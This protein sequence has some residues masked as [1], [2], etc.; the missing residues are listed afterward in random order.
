MKNTLKKIFALAIVPVLILGCAAPQPVPFKLVDSESRI[1]KGTIFP[2][3]GQIEVTVD[4]QQYK[5]FYIAATGVA[6]S[7]SFGGWRS[8]PRNTVTTYSSNSARAQLVTDS[9][10][11]LSCD[12]LFEDK[13]AIG[14]C[15]SPSGTVYQLVAD[16]N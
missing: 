14:Q 4:G 15:R 10:L 5:G 7:E 9:G 13:R 2:D 16:G 8:F 6:Y 12:F 1:Q 3:K 11:R